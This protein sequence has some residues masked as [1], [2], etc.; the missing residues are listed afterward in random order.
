MI[1][2]E[3]KVILFIV[4]GSSDEIILRSC[5]TFIQTGEL[6]FEVVYGDLTSDKDSTIQNIKKKINSALVRFCDEKNFMKKDISHIIHVVDTDGTYIPDVNV[7]EASCIKAIYEDQ[8]IVCKNARDIAL[9]NQKKRSILNLLI[10]L[11]TVSKIPYSVYYFSCNLD[12]F[13][14]NNANLE[15]HLKTDYAEELDRHFAR[16]P[17][18][19]LKLLSCPGISSSLTYTQ[20]WD[21]IKQYLNSLSRYTNLNLLFDT[22]AKNGSLFV[23]K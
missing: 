8:R 14:H 7:E 17:K 4:E 3:R 5:K 1:K 9:R 20:S 2:N 19:F 18:D 10:G 23:S 21:Y 6:R 22:R 15:S 11:T 16:N 13:F 12:H